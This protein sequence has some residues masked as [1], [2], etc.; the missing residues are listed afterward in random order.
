MGICVWVLSYHV[1][2]FLIVGYSHK[3]PRSITY[4]PWMQ[5]TE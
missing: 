2:F 4:G 3:R 5:G 1:E